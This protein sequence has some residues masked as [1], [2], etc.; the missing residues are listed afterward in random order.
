MAHLWTLDESDRW[1][2]TTLAD[3][4]VH[5]DATVDIEADVSS[6]STSDDSLLIQRLAAAPETWALV[7][8]PGWPGRFN[9]EL[10][11]LGLVI[12]ADRD[13]IRAPGRRTMFFSTET[14]AHVEPYAGSDDRGFC[15]RCKQPIEAGTAAVRCPSCGLWHHESDD[16]PCWTYAPRCTA[17][18]HETA[19]DA[20]YRWS[21]EE[22]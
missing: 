4:R 7:C 11:P 20:S 8:P 21:P 3:D 5:L 12:L 18:P 1:V 9:G 13:E 6:E 17:C 14:I 2:A 15:P 19:L 16:L 10:V 22:L